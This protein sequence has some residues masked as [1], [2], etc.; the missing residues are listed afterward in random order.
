G[1]VT[2]GAGTAA[3]GAEGAAAAESTAD[4][5]DSLA[6]CS[7]TAANCAEIA[8]SDCSRRRTSSAAPPDSDPSLTWPPRARWTPLTADGLRVME[9]SD[10]PAGIAQV[11]HNPQRGARDRPTDRRAARTHR[12]GPHAT[13]APLPRRRSLSAAPSAPHQP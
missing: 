3:A 5:A 6:T 8:D 9:P 7:A 10:P 1:A 11:I 2:K 4:A 12:S 13:S